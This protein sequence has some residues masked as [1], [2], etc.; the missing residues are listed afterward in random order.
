[1][2]L[3]TLPPICDVVVVAII[4]KSMWNFNIKKIWKKKF[5]I[6]KNYV[7]RLCKEIGKN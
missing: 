1:M 2:N 7:F 5:K 6:F 3:Y 4:Q